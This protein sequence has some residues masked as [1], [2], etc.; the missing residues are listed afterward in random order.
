MT[1]IADLQRKA[2]AAREFQVV[3]GACTYTLRLPTTHQ[4]EVAAMR[5][6]GDGHTA[7]PALA[8]LLVRRLVEQS[9]VAWSG[10]TAEHLAPGGGADVAELV[11]GAVALLLDNQP[12][13]ARQ[14]TD[15]MVA[16]ENERNAH[17]E[18]ARKN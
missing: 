17:A 1:D 3:V 10:V 6:R 7:D 9:V 14:L 15:A 12:E 8:V 13:T 2:N 4:K 18:A 16:R 5:A 11:P